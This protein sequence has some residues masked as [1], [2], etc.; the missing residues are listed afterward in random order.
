MR[1]GLVWIVGVYGTRVMVPADCFER[2]AERCH[3]IPRNETLR[4]RAPHLL[5]DEEGL[6]CS[7]SSGWRAR[8]GDALPLAWVTLS[9]A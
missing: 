9:E 1:L 3:A 4:E 6:V 5:R 2:K 7:M 8:I